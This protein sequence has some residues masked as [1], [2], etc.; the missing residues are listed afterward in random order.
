MGAQL[1]FL[2]QQLLK[3]STG[4]SLNHLVYPRRINVRAATYIT[5]LQTTAN[6]LQEL[7]RDLPLQFSLYIFGIGCI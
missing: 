6:G 5:I 2:L 4:C 1:D 3:L 7:G